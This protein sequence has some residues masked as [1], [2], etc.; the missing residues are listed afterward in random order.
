LLEYLTFPT[1][2]QKDTFD[3]EREGVL[4]CQDNAENNIVQIIEPDGLRRTLL[5]STGATISIN[6]NIL[7]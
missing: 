4:V 2:K 7:R 6:Q 1:W 5:F 3:K